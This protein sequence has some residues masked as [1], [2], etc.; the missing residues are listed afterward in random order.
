MCVSTLA[1]SSS[2]RNLGAPIGGAIGL[3]FYL[4]TVLGATMYLLGAAEALQTGF[5]LNGL[6]FMDREIIALVGMLVLTIVVYVGM[7]V[8]S[9]VAFVFLAVVL[10]SMF[11]GLA[12]V[13]LF[14]AGVDFGDSSEVSR[15]DS[16]AWGSA[17]QLDPDTGTTP[18][19]VTALSVFYPAVTGIMAGANRSGMLADPSKA[20]PRGTMSAIATTTALYLGVIFMF[21]SFVGRDTLLG[22]KL[23]FATLAWPIKYVVAVGVVLS[24]FG[25]GMQCLAGAP[26]LLAKMR[27]DGVMPKFTC[28]WCQRAPNSGKQK[29][30]EQPKGERTAGALEIW[31]TW[32]LASLPCLAGNLDSI[33]PIQTMFFLMM[34]AAINCSVLLL[35]F[36]KTPNFRPTFKAYS[37]ITCA[38]GIIGCMAIMLLI[39]WWQ[40]LA[41][42]FVAGGLYL[43]ISRT[44][45]SAEWG[46]WGD[47]I[48]AARLTQATSALLALRHMQFHPRNWRPQLLVMC[49]LNE[50]DMSPAR[51]GLLAVA[52]QIKSGRGLTI[53]G[54][55]LPGKVITIM[56]RAREAYRASKGAGSLGAWQEEDEEGEGA[57]VAAWAAAAAAQANS[58]EDVLPVEPEI[59]AL[60]APGARLQHAM[61]ESGVAGFTQCLWAESMPQG[62]SSLLQLAGIGALAP[63]MVLSGWPRNWVGSNNAP[64]PDAVDYVAALKTALTMRKALVAVKG[65]DD[66]AL[67]SSTPMKG[68]IDIWWVRVDSGLLLLLP[69][70]L[71]RH[72]KWARCQ[73]RLFAV[74]DASDDHSAT[75]VERLREYLA[76]QRIPAKLIV[77]RTEGHI[78]MDAVNGRTL[79]ADAREQLATAMQ[80]TTMTM[81]A[82]PQKPRRPTAMELFSQGGKQPN[83]Q[84]DTAAAAIPEDAQEPE[85][86]RMSQSQSTEAT[87][88]DIANA[89]SSTSIAA[90][91]EQGRIAEAS[92]RMKAAEKLNDLMREHSSE[93]ALVVTN[94]FINRH[95]DPR[96]LLSSV[97]LL[98]SG[99]PRALLVR[100]TG[101]EMVTTFEASSVAETGAAVHGEIVNAA[102][103]GVH[104]QPAVESALRVPEEEYTPVG[105]PVETEQS[106]LVSARDGEHVELTEVNVQPEK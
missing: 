88:F 65:D 9:K 7:S 61:S 20:I 83:F 35:M 63:N 82:S 39:S 62:V 4:G 37:P 90:T 41:A 86:M 21:G 100:G 60:R 47:S 87:D 89:A 102:E 2:S 69:F 15:A 8:V 78:A 75:R 48:T 33:T 25:A 73:L 16:P 30:Q 95:I 18:S 28:A 11:L 24:S 92:R 105:T 36:M 67:V 68:T 93:A 101:G 43:W 32:F 1:Q 31:L 38:L 6:F 98:V 59:A 81:V 76:V 57:N 53:V 80:A 58:S 19:F 42:A 91:A 99:L 50:E 14:A 64:T 85:G 26:Q 40:A 3:L 49:K 23:V 72:P 77:L 96:L 52:G 22:D 104:V 51:P 55:V 66:P 46:S 13:V 106:Q 54:S 70:L 17:F 29:Q 5:G 44:G 94:L 34:Y 71:T 12:G 10:V 97:T 27:D 45:D 79:T 56:N 74:E 84:E 103:E